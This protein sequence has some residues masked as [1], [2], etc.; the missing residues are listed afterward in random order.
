[1]TA[2]VVSVDIA[3]PQAEVFAYVT[4]PSRFNEWQA[5]VTGGSMEGGSDPDVGAKCTTTRRI[6]GA[7][8]TATSTVTKVD[9]PTMWGVQGWRAA[10]AWR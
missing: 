6:G 10:V 4:D 5:G 3:R 8:R 1:M 9:P 7:E 2:T